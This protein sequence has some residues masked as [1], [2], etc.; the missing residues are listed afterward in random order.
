[1]LKGIKSEP[2][3]LERHFAKYKLRGNVYIMYLKTK[4]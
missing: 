4:K 1:M 2:V 3:K